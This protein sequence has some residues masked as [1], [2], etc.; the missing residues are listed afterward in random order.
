MNTKETEVLE[1]RSPEEI[2]AEVQ[3]IINDALRAS[4]V[5][6]FA[7]VDGQN[8][9]WKRINGAAY[10]EITEDMSDKDIAQFDAL[11]NTEIQNRRME[12]D[13]TQTKRVEA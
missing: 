8:L 10:R 7:I 1:T 3:R 4:V 13:T 6:Y 12:E 9:D 2:E 11:L 5:N